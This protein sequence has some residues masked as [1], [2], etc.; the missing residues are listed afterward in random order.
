M[1]RFNMTMVTLAVVLTAGYT[2][3]NAQNNRGNQYL[4]NQRGA[5]VNSSGLTT[6]QTAEIQK[7]SVAHQSEMDALRTELRSTSNLAQ[8]REIR[9]QMDQIQVKHRAKITGLGATPAN[10]PHSGFIG[11]GC[12]AGRGAGLGAGRASGGGRGLGP[13]GAGLGRRR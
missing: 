8:R 11:R 1:K 6:V 5:C 2:G 3:L 9:G 10:T 13:C 4:T 12:G 7:L